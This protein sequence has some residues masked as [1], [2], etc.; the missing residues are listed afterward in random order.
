[1]DDVQSAASQFIHLSISGIIIARLLPVSQPI[2][3][4]VHTERA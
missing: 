3:A 4:S 1:M 2:S